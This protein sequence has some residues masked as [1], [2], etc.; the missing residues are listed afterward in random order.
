M[1]FADLHIHTIYSYDGTAS[2]AAVLKRAKQIGLDIIA[3]TDHDEIRGSLQ[4]LELASSYGIDVLPGVEVTTSEGDLLALNIT[5][6][7]ERNLSLVETV[8]RVGG[9]GGFCIVPHLMARGLGMKSLSAYSIKKALRHP[10][11]A[12]I[13]IGVE[14]YNATAIEKNSNRYA[15]ILGKHLEIAMLGNSDAHI[16]E[17]IGLGMTEF[18]GHTNQ[19]LVKAIQNRETVI[20]KKKAWNTARILGSW[21]V[22]YIASTVTRLGITA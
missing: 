14:T 6:R 13:L 8:L 22:N 15:H 12:Q 9:M 3:I 4:A 10:G 17:A 7:I 19:D 2:V 5:E 21:A 16:L 11:V 20:H 18:P 1:G